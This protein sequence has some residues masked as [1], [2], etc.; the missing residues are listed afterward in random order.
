MDKNILIIGPARSGKTTLSRMISKEFDYSIINLDDIISAFESMPNSGIKHD[1]DDIETAKKFGLFLKTYLKELSE[2]PNFY[3]GF[4][5]VIEGTHIDF[6]QIMPMLNSEKYKDKYIVIGLL[7]DKVKEK[8]LY[9]NIKKYDTEDDWTYWCTDEELKGNVSYFIDR[10]KYFKEK[11]EKYKIDTF[12]V[13][14]NREEILEEIIKKLSKK[15]VI[16]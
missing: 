1:G 8:E 7:Y 16:K 14:E 9:D 13:S 3:S 11:F 15:E 5:F 2:G 12:D 6:E 10:N 4:K